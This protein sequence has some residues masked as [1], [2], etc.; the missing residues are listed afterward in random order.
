MFQI[1]NVNFLYWA[2]YNWKSC[3]H[4]IAFTQCMF[5]QNLVNFNQKE[6]LTKIPC[7]RTVS[8]TGWL[9]F[10]LHSSPLDTSRSRHLGHHPAWRPLGPRHLLGHRPDHLGHYHQLLPLL[11]SLPPGEKYVHYLRKAWF[12]NKFVKVDEKVKMFHGPFGYQNSSWSAQNC[13]R[14]PARDKQMNSNRQQRKCCCS[15]VSVVAFRCAK[16]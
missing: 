7:N 8:W 1:S 2:F 9:Q 10:P 6:I 13:Y 11:P 16:M 5:W 14:C 15:G 4:M 3:I 12:S